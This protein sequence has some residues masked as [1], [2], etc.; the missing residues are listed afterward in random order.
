MSPKDQYFCAFQLDVSL[1]AGDKV[2]FQYAKEFPLKVPGP[3][4]ERTRRMGVSIEDSFPVIE[5]KYKLTVLL[6]NTAGKE[7]SILEQDIDVPDPEAPSGPACP[8]SD[9]G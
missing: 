6:R 8:S 2:V 7:F 4:I 5:G 3:E 1:R 9:I